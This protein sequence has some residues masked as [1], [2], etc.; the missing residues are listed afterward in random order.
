MAEQ[1]S[2]PLPRTV[3]W[4]GYG[5]LL[6]FL[7]LA[8]ASLLDHHHGMVWSDALYAYG[9][10]ILSFIGALHWG[11]AMSLPGL[12]ERQRSAW[13]MWSIVPALIAWPAV[14][15]SPPL[16]APLLIAGFIAHYLQDRRLAGQ[17]TLPDW[18]LPLRL[19]L[20]SVAAVCLVAGV[21]ATCV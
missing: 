16:A 3:A 8:P 9:A 18:Y 20:T 21:F 17:A 13:F 7:A 11:L 5:G 12:T 15:F 10:I 6:P 2:L 14:L 19:R 1:H 4:L